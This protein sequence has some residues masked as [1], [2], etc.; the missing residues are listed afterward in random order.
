MNPSDLRLCRSLLFL[1]ASNP[2]AIEKARQLDADMVILDLEDAVRDED[3]ENARSA[4]IGA[5]T[6][7]FPGLTAI[8]I[9]AVGTPWYGT[10]A[11]SMRDSH[12]DLVVLPKAE[13]Y[14]EVKDTGNLTGKPV[15]A[16][17]ETPLG[18]VNAIEI[19]PASAG[20]IAGTNDLSLGLGLPVGG[21]REGLAYSLQAIV[22]A[23]RSFNG[24]AFDGVYNRLDD[25]QGFQRQCEDGRAFGFDGKALI[26]PG[27]IEAANRIFGPT[28][29]EIAAAE[30]LIAAHGGGA[31]RFEGG[32]V[33]NLHVAQ[34]HAVLAKAR[35]VPR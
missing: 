7:G 18:V 10:D 25:V 14:K 21:P 12:V 26:H 32:M 11:V 22:L 15:L 2:R 28:A 13:S 30:R 1:P 8:R 34:A 16:M 5:A 20:L 9:N 29:E 3:K 31:E 33:E 4:A 17:I 23:A 19:A 27:Q 6:E 24:A 35:R